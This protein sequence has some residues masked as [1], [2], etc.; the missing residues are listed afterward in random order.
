MTKHFCNYF[1]VGI[2]GKVGY[3]FDLHRTSSRIGNMMVYGVMGAVKSFTKTKTVGELTKQFKQN[4]LEIDFL[5]TANSKKAESTRQ[6]A[7]KRD[8][9][10]LE[11][12]SLTLE[13]IKQNENILFLNINSF[14][15]GVTDIWKNAELP[16]S[17]KGTNMV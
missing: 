4:N 6:I 2:D 8:S 15:A 9:A 5:P 14:M 1:S 7:T 17:L 3:S 16:E 11:R 12:G 13:E 10:I